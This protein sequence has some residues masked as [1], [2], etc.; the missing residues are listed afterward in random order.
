MGVNGP[1]RAPAVRRAVAVLECLTRQG[2]ANLTELSHQ[3][4]LAKS[5][6]SDLLSTMLQED[7]VRKR[8]DEFILGRLL[9]E[10]TA[11]FVGEEQILDRF[12]KDWSRQPILGEHTVSVQAIIGTHSLCADVRLGRYLLPYT[13]RAG[14]RRMIWDGKKGEPV[15]RSLPAESVLR[16]VDAYAEYDPP[17][18]PNDLRRWVQ[19]NASGAQHT[20]M[21]ASNGNVELSVAITP[22]HSH[23]PP[24]ALSLHFPPRMRDAASHE[25]RQALKD[26]ARTVGHQA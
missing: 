9:S 25:L 7:L 24:V 23:G 20:A 11:G 6:T 13:P 26:F 18:N 8:G 22:S 1:A 21:L 2:A 17:R 16:T 14:S 12:A 5:S 10:L 19:N 3:L 15:L 4:G